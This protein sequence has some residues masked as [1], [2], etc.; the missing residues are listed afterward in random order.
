M[1]SDYKW[2]IRLSL[3]TPLLLLIAL[4]CM[5][6][7]HGW[8]EPAVVLFPFSLFTLNFDQFSGIITI[9]VA[10][11]QFPLYGLLIDKLQDK[12]Y[13]KVILTTVFLIHI[14]LVVRIL[15][16]DWNEGR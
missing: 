10:F 11:I 5:G 16:I 13:K 3:L 4:F 12:F 8:Y 9:I 2:T 14:L 15:M 1:N 7:G 6:G